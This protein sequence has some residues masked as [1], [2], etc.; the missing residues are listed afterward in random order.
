MSDQMKTRLWW[1]KDRVTVIPDG[2]DTQLF[3]PQPQREARERLGWGKEER[4]VL[5]N[6]SMDPIVKDFDLA[7]AAIDIAR[8]ICGEIRWIVLDGHVSPQSIPWMM[9]AAD[10]LLLTSRWEGSPNVVKEAIACSLPVVSVDVGDVCERLIGV[11]PSA[12]VK[13]D[14]EMIARA[15]AEMLRKPQRSNG[16]D[17][18]KAIS[19]S[20]IAGKI[21]SVYESVF[22]D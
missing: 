16:S 15:L 19:E 6:A 2:V 1:R 4:I 12:I 9:N 5:F 17:L 10:C 21:S 8:Q 11:E 20:A 3:Y 22:S 14:P 13:R 18:I 7:K